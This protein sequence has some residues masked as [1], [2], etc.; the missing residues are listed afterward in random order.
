MNGRFFIRARTL[1]EKVNALLSASI[2]IGC[3]YGA[4]WLRFRGSV[5]RANTLALIKTTPWLLVL[6]V[7]W[8]PVTGLNRARKGLPILG[9]SF[10]T[11]VGICAGLASI[12]F[13]IREFAFPRSVLVIGSAISVFALAAWQLLFS[14]VVFRV[15]KSRDSFIVFTENVEDRYDDRDGRYQIV[16]VSVQND[17]IDHILGGHK[18]ATVVVDSSVTPEIRE[19]ILQRCV[20]YGQQVF[21][22]PRLY[23]LLVH[24]GGLCENNPSAMLVVNGINI[25]FAASSVKRVIDIV[26]SVLGLV[27]TA[28]IAPLIALANR[29]WS[30]GPLFYLQ[31]RVGKDEKP[32]KIVKFRTMIVDAEKDTGPVL[33]VRD[34][35]RVTPVGRILRATRLDELPQAWNVLKGEMS[36]IGPRA[37]RPR[38]VA[39]FKESIPWYAYRFRVKP[40]ITGLA[41]VMGRYDTPTEDKLRYD[42]MYICNYSIWM[43]IR[44]MYE[45]ARVV[46]QAEG[47]EALM[48]VLPAR[49]QFGGWEREVA[50]TVDSPR[51]D[52]GVN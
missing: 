35:P 21:L 15:S 32:F 26:F 25:P 47:S 7:V 10:L 9:R 39:Q 18:D 37:E 8:L 36:L 23:D 11:G 13:L 50:T 12:A 5:P 1:L 42:L 30:P 17:Q 2:V 48:P 45:T 43:D 33:A 22:T 38:F 24:S 6:L 20:R 49:G 3:F 28:L 41:Q 16:N 40:G 27:C 34:D 31:E 19:Y 44:L 14:T 29:L 4:L 46:L 51:Q 52:A